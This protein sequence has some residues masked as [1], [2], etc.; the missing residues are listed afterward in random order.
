MTKE[1]GNE[2]QKSLN[3]MSVILVSGRT[4]NK[5]HGDKTITP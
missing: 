1:A 2:C 5:G 4:L 3:W